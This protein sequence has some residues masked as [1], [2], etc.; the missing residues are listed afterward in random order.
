MVQQQ[1]PYDIA[2]GTVPTT[3]LNS[4]YPYATFGPNT[5]LQL[6]L[7][8]MQDQANRLKV[9]EL[10]SSTGLR[11][12]IAAR[13]FTS[14]LGNQ[15]GIG[16]AFLAGPMQEITAPNVQYATSVPNVARPQISMPNIGGGGG[17]FGGSASYSGS[18]GGG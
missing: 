16:S 11:D 12:A 1:N 5:A 14:G 9:A 7:Q 10:A 18:Y 17:G 4:L 3:A 13:F 2:G 15:P 6:V 8:Q